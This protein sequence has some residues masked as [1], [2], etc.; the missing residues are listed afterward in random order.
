VRLVA[1]GRQPATTDSEL[2]LRLKVWQLALMGLLCSCR[3]PRS[4]V[5]PVAVVEHAVVGDPG[6]I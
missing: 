2:L 6:S 1:P 3:R 4:P 5:V